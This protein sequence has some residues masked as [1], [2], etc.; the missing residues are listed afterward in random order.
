MY[1]T[2]LTWPQRGRLWLRLGIRLVG[3]V[4]GVALVWVLGPPLLSLFMPF[5]LALVAAVLLNPLVRWL[6]RKLGWPR[7]LL[8]LLVLLVIFGLIG[9]ALGLLLR[10]AVLELISLAENWE[11]LLAA[12][13]QAVER[14]DLLL[15]DLT[16][17]LPI[18]ITT[19]DQTLL[20]R[21]MGWVTNWLQTAMPDLGNLT[22]FAREQAMGVSS[23]VL[24]TI[25]FLMGSY[26]I[27]ADY[28]YLRTRCVQH[29]DEG[30]RNFLRQVRSTALAAFG[31]YIK[32]EVLLSVGVFF[33]L[34]AGFLLMRQSYA[35]LLALGLAILDF[36]PIVG[37]G[38]VMVPWAVI[39][40][41]TGD[42]AT[43]AWVMV[44]WGAVAMFRRVAE[45]KFVGNQTGLSPI[46]SLISIYVGMKVAGVAGMI[47]GPIVT[48]VILNLLGIGLLD[49]W[50]ADLRLALEDILAILSNRERRA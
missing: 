16:A 20:D 29:M 49:G 48:L 17:Q 45:P 33:I 18:Q 14:L 10:A 7:K 31:G 26:F 42:Y 19:P 35:L 6:Q 50:K 41:F 9:S 47:L 4:L 5:V 24:A 38:T 11:T 28:P 27:T 25:M 32:A 39:A 1:H 3:T 34:L 8:S 43:A 23:F 21:V 36:I 30:L 46:L 2:E 44:I 40:L 37:S 22:A 12:A 15:Q 13:Q